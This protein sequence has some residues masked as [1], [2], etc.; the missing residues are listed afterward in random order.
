MEY[1][2]NR[3]MMDAIRGRMATFVPKLADEFADPDFE[4]MK[5]ADLLK[6]A[7][8]LGLDVSQRA[9]KQEIIKAIKEA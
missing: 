9:T 3:Q 1:K 7:A 8:D 4:G 2:S 6:Y 5:K